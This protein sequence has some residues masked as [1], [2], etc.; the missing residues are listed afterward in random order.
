MKRIDY[1]GAWKEAIERYFPAFVAFLFPAVYAAIDWGQEYEFLNKELQ[2]VV[3]DANIGPRRADELVKVWLRDGHEAWVLV[4]IEVQ[5]QEEAAFVE[6]MYVYNYRI[7]DRYRRSVVSLA[8][9]G[10]E[11]V[12]W[13]PHRYERELLGCRV[14]FE[15]PTVKLADYRNRWEELEASNNPF[16]TV[17]MAHLKAQETRDD[18]EQRQAWK[19]I[20]TRRLYEKGYGREDVLSLFRFI[21]WLLQLPEAAEQT[22][23]EKVQ[24]YEEEG[25]MTYITSVERMGIEKGLQQGLQQGLRQGLL[26]GIKLGLEARFGEKGLRLLPEIRQ[27]EDV[28]VLQAIQRVLWTAATLDEV[29][30]VYA[31]NEDADLPDASHT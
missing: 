21:D 6:R 16:A 25:K 2:Q 8:V 31:G 3:R 17:V 14:L 12:R 29:R 24:A 11:N 18:V 28:D 5:G 13:R 1:D 23:W 26:T 9:L 27:I 20:L 4:H 15:F 10:D 7:F 30:Q 22:F 19:F